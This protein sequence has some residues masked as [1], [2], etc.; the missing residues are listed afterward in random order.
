MGTWPSQP[1]VIVN[2]SAKKTADL[3]E[4][5]QTIIDTVQ[6]QFG[7]LLEQEPELLP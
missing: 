6:E 1:L 5:R 2:E 3:L 4:F 7:V